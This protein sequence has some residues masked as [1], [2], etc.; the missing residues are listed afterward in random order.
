MRVFIARL[1]GFYFNLGTYLFPKRVREQAFNLLCK[2]KKLPITPEGAEFF[3]R[4]STTFTDVY[5]YR[6][7]LHKW[8]D[9]PKKILFLH[10]WMSHSQR[11]KSYV[12]SLDLNEYTCYAL[13]APGHGTSEGNFLNL[14]IYREAY[15][16]AL[17]QIGD[18]D[19]LVAHSLGNLVA[20]YQY[21]YNPKIAVKSYVIMGS[22]SGMDAIFEYFHELLGLSQAMMK[23]LSVKIKEVLKVDPS[24]LQLSEFFQ[25]NTKPKLVIHEISDSVT[26][27]GPIREGIQGAANVTAYFT[28]GLDHTL[29]GPDVKEKVI[30]FIK[31]ITKNQI[32][33]FERV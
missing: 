23:N 33:V 24:N 28:E 25:S 5:G 22:P 14:E 27:I 6:T 2:V 29:K 30:N 1:I 15:E 32:H 9:G 31:D 13:D 10:G 26:P 8:G 20:A 11:W 4:G 12:D 3:K 18:V 16:T 21:F 7:A 17:D 19:V